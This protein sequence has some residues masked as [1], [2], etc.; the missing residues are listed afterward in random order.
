MTQ[1]V[2]QEG[3]VYITVK[4]IRHKL[5]SRVKAIQQF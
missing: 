5:C 4:L 1:D 2:T 3:N